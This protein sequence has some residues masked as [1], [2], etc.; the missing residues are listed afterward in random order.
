MREQVQRAQA[1]DGLSL[2]N[3]DTRFHLRFLDQMKL[4]GMLRIFS[5]SDFIDQHIQFRGVFDGQP[6]DHVHHILLL[7][8]IEC[9]EFGHVVTRLQN[10]APLDEGARPVDS[11]SI[12]PWS[13]R[14]QLLQ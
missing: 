5:P 3:T 8:H 9:K 11:F 2:G 7:G 6:D 13:R 10:G 14:R 12:P 1:A 4:K